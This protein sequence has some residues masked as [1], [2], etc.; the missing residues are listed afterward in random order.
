QASTDAA[1]TGAA[2]AKLAGP[3]PRPV[4]PG[5]LPPLALPW[6]TASAPWKL[7]VTG[8]LLTGFG[9][10]S[11]AGVTSRGL[12]FA[13]ASGAEVVAPAAGRV[14]YAGPFRDYGD[15]VIIDHAGG[16]TT[17]VSGLGA[18]AVKLNQPVGQGALIGAA[19]PGADRRVTVELRRR[20]RAV[21]PVALTG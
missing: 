18:L 17:L 11:D 8:K 2:L 4:Q 16:W 3:L 12:T 7:P 13:V 1:A 5:E 9:E 6:S 10:V 19:P 14:V 20:G 21:D 15:V